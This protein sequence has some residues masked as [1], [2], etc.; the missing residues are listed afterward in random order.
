VVLHG[1]YIDVNLP[2]FGA[3][4]TAAPTNYVGSQGDMQN[5]TIFDYLCVDPAQIAFKNANGYA[6]NGCTPASGPPAPFR[7][8]FG[9]CSSAASIKISGVTDGKM[10][11]QQAR[12]KN[13]ARDD[14][15]TV[16]FGGR[17]HRF[18]VPKNLADPEASGIRVQV[19]TGSN[20]VDFAIA[21]D[22]SVAVN[23]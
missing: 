10:L 11:A 3:Q 13:R 17:V 4:L 2:V 6:S 20:R 16:S 18:L 8:I 9:D 5:N 7:G 15:P 19:S 14:A 23:E 22:G 12:R 1:F 21:E